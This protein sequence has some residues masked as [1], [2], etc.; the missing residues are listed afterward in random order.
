M[1]QFEILSVL[2]IAISPAI[3][4]FLGV[5]VDRL[6][7]GEDV[8]LTPSACRSCKA[9]LRWFD[10][11]PVLS[12]LA[13]KGRCRLCSSPIPPWNLYI[14]LLAIGAAVLGVLTAQGHM[15]EAVLTA[16]FLWM[17]LAL[18]IADARWFRLP[19]ALN[20]VLAAA[21]FALAALPS[22]M[23]LHALFGA[24]FGAISFL[25][26]RVTY[27]W[28]RGREGLGLGDVKLM[29]GLGAFV[30]PF[31]LPWMLMIAA[32]T[33]LSVAL[34]QHFTSGERVDGQ[35]PLPFGTA[36]CAATF[37]IWLARAMS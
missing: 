1:S 15:V 33:A 21:A 10:L 13:Q 8:I 2:L 4:S 37:A 19:D 29:I 20:F 17:L 14:E 30:G 24:L 35:T 27:K 34:V 6:P 26:L 23:G 22:G 28:L 16:I 7:R 31:T 5:L 18:A 9:N 36:L 3:G 11:V 32:C 12:F 25:I